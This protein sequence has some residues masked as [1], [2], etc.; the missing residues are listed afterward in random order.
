MPPSDAAPLRFIGP[1]VTSMTWSSTRSMSTKT[2]LGERTGCPSA[3]APFGVSRDCHPPTPSLYKP[4]RWRGRFT[5]H[6]SAGPPA[7]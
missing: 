6:G 2:S 1:D 7:S 5:I 3:T 4:S